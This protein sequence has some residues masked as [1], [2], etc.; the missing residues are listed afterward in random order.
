MKVLGPIQELEEDAIGGRYE[1][2]LHPT[3]FNRDLKAMLADGLLGSSFAF[4]VDHE[5]VDPKPPRSHHNPT[6]IEERTIVQA[7]VSEFGPCVFPAYAEASAS[8]RSRSAVGVTRYRSLSMPAPT[9]RNPQL[10]KARRAW[11]SA[12]GPVSTSNRQIIESRR[13][14]KARARDAGPPE[15]RIQVYDPKLRLM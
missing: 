11:K 7:S 8:I 15:P 12:T 6:G 2:G 3:S 14:H 9:T 13:A 1:V 10:L 5:Q 4:Y